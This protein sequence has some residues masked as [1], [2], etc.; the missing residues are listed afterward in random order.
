MIFAAAV[1]IL[2]ADSAP[3]VPAILERVAREAA[4]FQ[5][6]APQTFSQE[7]LEQKVRKK[8]SR[9]L[10]RAGA[11]AVEAPALDYKTREVIS[12][13]S[14]GFLK[15]SPGLHEFRQVI[16]VDGRQVAG[17]E[18]ARHALSLGIQSA[19]DELKKRML[20]QFEK[21]GLTGAATD[22]GQLLLLFSE[23]HARDYEF[24]IEGETRIGA[25]ELYV[26]SWRQTSGPQAIVIFHGR[27]AIR[28]RMHGELLVRK[29]DYLPLRVSM[30][31]ERT[32]GKY[33]IRDEATVDYAET[34]HGVVLPAA[35]H[36]TES[37]NDTVVAENLFR[38]G[39]FHRFT[40][41]TRIEF[42]E[43]K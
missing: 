30:A 36:H 27:Q 21:Y 8:P 15:A 42:P 43:P 37:V 29:T 41:G 28:S 32:Q 14:F 24:E 19:D 10:P 5:R 2:R 38:Y 1:I 40:S 33:V 22:F 9:F 16:S 4:A 11:R 13:Y 39:G 3:P 23:R 6:I 25:D 31:T 35:V 20:E 12:E 18:K 7:T 34:A 17:I 26:L